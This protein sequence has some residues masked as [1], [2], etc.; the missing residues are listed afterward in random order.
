MFDKIIG[1]SRCFCLTALVVCANSLMI[2]PDFVKPAC[3][4]RL[5]ISGVDKGSRK[6][7][8]LYKIKGVPDFLSRKKKLL[9][10]VS[11]ASIMHIQGWRRKSTV[12]IVEIDVYK[13][14]K[15][16]RWVKTTNKNLNWNFFFAFKV[17]I[18]STVL[19][20]PL[21]HGY[22]LLRVDSAGC[23]KLLMHNP[24]CVLLCKM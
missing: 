15:I 6:V 13:S 17:P 4:Y 23:M 22:K 9:E 8:C 2:H 3:S 16:P 11:L 5:I 12:H 10:Y 1:P 20:S 7:A 19:F 14:S 21:Y 24:T 18:F